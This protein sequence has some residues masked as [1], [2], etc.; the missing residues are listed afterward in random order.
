VRE[1]KQLIRAVITEIGVTVHRQRRVADLRIVWQGG[2]V[3]E[4][5]MRMNKP[6]GR[7][8]VTDD[9]TI[10][11]IRRLAQHYDDRAIAAIL[12]KQR[13]RTATGLTFTRARVATLRADHTIPVHQ[14][15]CATRM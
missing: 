6:G 3:S 4:L 9:D 7:L 5:S 2:A 14:R 8:R 10:A 13:R 12:A 15:G 11:L 1:R